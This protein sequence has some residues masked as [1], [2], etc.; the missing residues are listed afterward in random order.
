MLCLQNVFEDEVNFPL[1]V[2]LERQ[3]AKKLPNVFNSEILEFFGAKDV[4]K[5]DTMQQ[6]FF[7]KTLPFWLAKTISPFNLLKAFG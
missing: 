6:N 1:K 4:Y 5:K 2:V 7:C 3:L